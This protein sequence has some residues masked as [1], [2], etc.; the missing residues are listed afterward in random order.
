[1][2]NMIIRQ[3]STN[4]TGMA[5]CLEYTLFSTITDRNTESFGVKVQNKI[6]GESAMIKDITENQAASEKLFDL[7][8]SGCVTP[9]SLKDVVEDYIAEI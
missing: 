5:K 8:I 2:K 1:M 4:F 3:N 9:V 7:L 6:T